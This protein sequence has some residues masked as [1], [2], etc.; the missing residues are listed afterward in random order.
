MNPK[1][2]PR[3]GHRCL[4][5]TF[6]ARGRLAGLT[7]A[8]LT[9]AGT[10]SVRGDQWVDPF[11]L[12][13]VY[14]GAWRSEGASRYSVY[15]GS[16]FRIRFHG[17]VK[18]VLSPDPTNPPKIKVR[19]L[20]ASAGLTH[21][22]NDRLLLDS[23][24]DVVEYEIA[25]QS[26]LDTVY[27]PSAPDYD[28]SRLSVLG[29]SLVNGTVLLPAT[30]PDASLHVEFLGDSILQGDR[31]LQGFGNNLEAMDGT[32]SFAYLVGRTRNISYRIR[33]YGGESVQT[34]DEKVP[35]FGSGIPLETAPPARWVVVTIGANDRALNQDAYQGHVESLL[36]SIQAVFPDAAI[37][38]LNF[39]NNTPN[40]NT[41]IQSAIDAVASASAVFFDAQPYLLDYTDQGIHP[42]RASH[43]FL[44]QA[45]LDFLDWR[46]RIIAIEPVPGMGGPRLRIDAAGCYIVEH[47]IDSEVWTLAATIGARAIWESPLPLNAAGLFRLSMPE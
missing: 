31:I 23:G 21:T 41:G 22:V 14:V 34:L 38:V 27:D 40:R 45:L 19:V 3:S 28:G 32:G 29:I 5:G 24:G 35:F 11:D 47:T 8:L 13:I 17:A 10:E 6:I 37:L 18:V 20:G 9:V 15:A 30:S 44:A 43:R 26:H 46:P 33:G 39:F 1:G 7:I 12:R 4:A 42:D 36:Q 2:I 16:H 25:L